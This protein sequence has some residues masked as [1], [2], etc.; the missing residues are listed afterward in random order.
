MKV[1][2]HLLEGTN[3]DFQQSPNHSGKFKTGFPDTIIVHFT[4]GSS[5]KSSVETLLNPKTKAS[6]HLVIAA[7]GAITQLMPFDM[8]AWHAGKS[9]YQGRSGFNKFSIGI[10]IDNLFTSI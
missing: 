9:T 5:A 2:A 10:E 3:I 7:D 6:A 8:V 1:K 4:A